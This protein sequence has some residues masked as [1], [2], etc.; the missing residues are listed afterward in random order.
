MP[1]LVNVVFSVKSIS[2]VQLL[3]AKLGS[4]E[5]SA[6]H[7]VSFDSPAVQL[8]ATVSAPAGLDAL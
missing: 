5:T 6:I 1:L 4:P 8:C 2:I 7:L 3:L